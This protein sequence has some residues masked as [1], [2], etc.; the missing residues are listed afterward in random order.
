MRIAYNKRIQSA[1]LFA[2]VICPRQFLILESATVWLIAHFWNR[3]NYYFINLPLFPKMRA[4]WPNI[5]GPFYTAH[6]GL[7]KFGTYVFRFHFNQRLLVTAAGNRKVLSFLG[8]LVSQV[9]ISTVNSRVQSLPSIHFKGLSGNLGT[10]KC[11]QTPCKC[12][13]VVCFICISS[14][15]FYH[16]QV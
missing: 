7:I 5:P 12:W 9:K 2:Y 3:V 11:F 13:Y 8:S 10:E 15:H 14:E 1:Y 4:M 16:E 6:I